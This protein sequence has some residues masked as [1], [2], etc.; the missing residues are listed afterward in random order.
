MD[1]LGR[2]TWAFTSEPRLLATGTVAGKVEAEGPL[3]A[4]FDVTVDDSSQGQSWEKA[5]QKLFASAAQTALVKAHKQASEIDLMVGSDLNAQLTSFYFGLRDFAIPA[6]GVY[7]ACS[8]ITEGLALAGLAIDSQVANH[9]MVGTSS[10]NATAERQFRYP[11][12]Y[13]AQKPPTAQRTVTG[14]GVAILGREGGNVA[15]THATIGQVV[16]Y[17]ITSPWEYGAAM[18][19]A[20]ARTIVAHLRETGRSLNDY[21]CVATGDLGRFGHAILLDLLAQDGLTVDTELTD[22][23]I[24]IFRQDQPEVFAGGSGAACSALVTFGYFLRNLE[25]GLWKRVLV[26]ATGA[27]LSTITAEQT[28]SIPAISHA[29]ALERKDG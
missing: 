13:G 3:G 24:L 9:V 22:C 6:L 15:V 19:P 2:Q 23:G 8:S 7:S 26:A 14:S 25:Q 20:A 16:D 5:E 1:K 28:E 17:G 11:T 18:A 10:H 12:E 4:N 27:L 21:D 29:I